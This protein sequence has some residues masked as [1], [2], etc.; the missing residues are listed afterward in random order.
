MKTQLKNKH[1][2]GRPKKES[3]MKH[4][5]LLIL[6]I[7]IIMSSCSSDDGPGITEEQRQLIMG[8]TSD[9]ILLLGL[10]SPITV[11]RDDVHGGTRELDM[12]R[13]GEIDVIITFYQEF[14]GGKGIQ[15][16]TPNEDANAEVAFD[17]STDWVRPLNAGEIVTFDSEDWRSA[18]MEPLAVFDSNDGSSSGLWNGTTSKYVAF[19][20]QINNTRFLAWIELSVSDYD[21]HSFHNYGIKIVP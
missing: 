15:I 17:P 2:I 13:N 8:D 19:R 20:M 5:W 16:S 11:E 3:T 14:F 7:T 18:D 12:D 6:P 10:Q 4:I 21:N 9:D 1:Y